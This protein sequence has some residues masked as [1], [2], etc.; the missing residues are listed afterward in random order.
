[1]K[2]KLIV[3]VALASLMASATLR[4]RGTEAFLG[5]NMV[6]SGS[7]LSERLATHRWTPAADSREHRPLFLSSATPYGGDGITTFALAQGPER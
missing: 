5:E 3:A 1:M 6:I 7:F 2:T 4:R